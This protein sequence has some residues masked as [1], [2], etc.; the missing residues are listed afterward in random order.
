MGVG[1]GEF[2]IG[3][4]GQSPLMELT[5]DIAVVTNTLESVERQKP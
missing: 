1:N 4:Y 3:G 2:S 5:G